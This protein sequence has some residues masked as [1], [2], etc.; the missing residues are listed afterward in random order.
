MPV[1]LTHPAT[2]VAQITIDN[3]AKHNAMSRE[4]LAELAAAW[5]ELETSACRAIV[6]T[7][8]GAKAFSAVPM[9]AGI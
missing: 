8:A 4:M 7:G 9:S 5:D 6:L 2:H 1:T 3:P